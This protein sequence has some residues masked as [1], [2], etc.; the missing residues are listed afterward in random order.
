MVE[1]G[2]RVQRAIEEI[3]GN[4]ALLEMLD[5]DAATEMLDWGIEMTTALVKETK[6]MDDIEAEQVLLPRLKAVRQT[7]RSVGNWAAGKYVESEDRVQL[8]E[9]LLRYLKIIFGDE[10]RLPSTEQM[11]ELLKQVDDKDNTPHQLILKLKQLVEES[12]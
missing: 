5:T 6:G 8:R 11:D 3:S 4:E 10:A 9:N 2:A 7:I 12:S 1:I